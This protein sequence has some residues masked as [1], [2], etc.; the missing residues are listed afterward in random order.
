MKV[1]IEIGKSTSIREI[2]EQVTDQIGSRTLESSGEC[3]C[4][5]GDG[6]SMCP[7]LAD[8]LDCELQ[9]RGKK[10]E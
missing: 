6:N 8:I 9:N 10:N 4:V 3:T 1:T 5:I 7:K 2:L